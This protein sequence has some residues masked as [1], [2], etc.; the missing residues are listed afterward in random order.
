MFTELITFIFSSLSFNLTLR[1]S[2]FFIASQSF[3][4]GIKGEVI[5][6]LGINCGIFFY[7][8]AL[9]FGLSEILIHYSCIFNIIK[10]KRRIYSISC[11]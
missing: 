10:N 7:L 6:A 2:V 3:G 5:A 4:R 11:F 9:T 1:N 8:L